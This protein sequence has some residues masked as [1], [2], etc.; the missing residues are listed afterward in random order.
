M[1]V[2]QSITIPL[3]HETPLFSEAAQASPPPE[4]PSPVTKATARESLLPAKPLAKR[5]TTKEANETARPGSARV[6]APHQGV[7]LPP[8]SSV[9]PERPPSRRYSSSWAAWEGGSS[10]RAFRAPLLRASSKPRERTTGA[11]GTLR[12]PLSCAWKRGLPP[13]AAFSSLGI[14]PSLAGA[15]QDARLPRG[16]GRG[17]H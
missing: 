10:A 13:A 7:S 14:P 3:P 16:R 9:V 17:P 5:S 11:S 15:L 2:T 4:P 6:S 1:L 8:P 12:L